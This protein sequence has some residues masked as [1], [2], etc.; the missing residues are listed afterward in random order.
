[1]K[2]AAPVYLDIETIIEQIDEHGG[3]DG[4]RNMGGLESAVA[5]PQA[6]FG[7][8]DLEGLSSLF[9][10]AWIETTLLKNKHSSLTIF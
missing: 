3:L 5:Q 10:E 1:M 2:F 7:S 4:I 9:R 6:T 8:E